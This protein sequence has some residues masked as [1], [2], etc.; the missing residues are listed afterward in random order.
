MI[1]NENI[2]EHKLH[3][4]AL[5]PNGIWINNDR[6]FRMEKMGVLSRM[7]SSRSR[8]G[9]EFLGLQGKHNSSSHGTAQDFAAKEFDLRIG[10]LS[11]GKKRNLAA[12][13]CQET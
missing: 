4:N 13:I 12:H 6:S 11:R 3:F 5:M 7:F 9:L 8:K 10:W 2:N 1:Q